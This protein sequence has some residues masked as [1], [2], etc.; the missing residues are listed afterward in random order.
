M[1]VQVEHI[2]VEK[3]QKPV[4]NLSVD[5]AHCFYANGVLVHNCDSMVMAMLRFRQGGFIRLPSDEQDD[6]LPYRQKVDYY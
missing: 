4:Y 5:G 1:R 6:E 2:S 3:G